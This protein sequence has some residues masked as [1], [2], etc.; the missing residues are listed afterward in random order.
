MQVRHHEPGALRHGSLMEFCSP[1]LLGAAESARRWP[2]HEAPT[3][4]GCSAPLPV[5]S[6]PHRWAPWKGSQGALRWCRE[7][8]HLSRSRGDDGKVRDDDLHPGRKAW[9]RIAL[10]SCL[11]PL[12]EGQTWP[13]PSL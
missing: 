1:H 6:A 2:E 10:S 8:R 5:P 13:P 11:L 4:A 12:Q 9:E 7:G 3:A